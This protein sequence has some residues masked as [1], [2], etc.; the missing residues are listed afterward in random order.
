M[1]PVSLADLIRTAKGNGGRSAKGGGYVEADW[2]RFQEAANKAYQPCR[3][4]FE[5]QSLVCRRICSG[6]YAVY[7]G[8][9]PSR[10]ATTVAA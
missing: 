5:A 2:Q 9:P 7:I 6:A 3:D 8:L 4:Y 10:S 1:E